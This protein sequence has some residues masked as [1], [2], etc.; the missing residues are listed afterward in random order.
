MPFPLLEVTEGQPGEFVATK[1][2]RAQ[3]GE[4]GPITFALDLLPVGCLP[5]FLPL[6]GAQPVAKPDAQLLDA[7]DP[8]YSGGQV[9][10]EQPAVCRLV[11]KTAQRSEAPRISRLRGRAI[12]GSTSHYRAF[13][14]DEVFASSPLASKRHRL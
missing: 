5:E 11:R 14:C 1:S 10:A 9:G 12:A 8:P 13:L 4:Q 6:L 7:L 3:E 2:A